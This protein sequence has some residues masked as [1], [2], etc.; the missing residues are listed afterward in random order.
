MASTLCDA[1]NLDNL[2]SVPSSSPL[3]ADYFPMSVS[4][5]GMRV[6]P[7]QLQ[8]TEQKMAHNTITRTVSWLEKA[9]FILSKK[10][11]DVSTVG[12]VHSNTPSFIRN[13]DIGGGRSANDASRL[14][15]ELKH[16]IVH[17]MSELSRLIETGPA[18]LANSRD[19]PRL[20]GK[21]NEPKS[22]L[23]CIEQ[24]IHCN[25][26][27]S[28][29]QINTRILSCQARVDHPK[30]A[31]D[32]FDTIENAKK[33]KHT[34]NTG[35]NIHGE[36]NLEISPNCPMKL[37]AS[38]SS[39]ATP[40]PIIDEEDDGKRKDK[41]SFHQMTPLM[42]SSNHLPD[43]VGSNWKASKRLKIESM[44]TSTS[45]TPGEN[46]QHRAN[47]EDAKTFVNFLQSV[48]RVRD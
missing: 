35:N 45:T 14:N 18:I 46:T 37:L 22:S 25:P 44:S 28:S 43:H 29:D 20:L 13:D 34:T 15:E 16:K 39:Q 33:R 12:V 31:S 40:V 3:V 48:V 42:P 1:A 19:L 23:Q 10:K 26:P 41:S 30:Q 47:A 32:S 6:P 8:S 38:L 27:S 21:Q 24:S 7:D 36:G 5:S 9:E 2:T 11:F 4:K 17:E